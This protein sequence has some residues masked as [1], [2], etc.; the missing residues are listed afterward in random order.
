MSANIKV[1]VLVLGAGPAGINAAVAAARHGLTVVLVDQN[2]AA[3]GQVFRPIPAQFQLNATHQPSPE[4]KLGDEQRQKLKQSNVQVYASHTVWN[5]SP[6]FRVD[7]VGPDGPVH[8]DCQAV[9]AAGG[10]TERVVPFPGWTLPGVIGLAAATIMLKSQNMVP[11]NNTLVA[12]CGPLLAA[13]AAGIIK[14]GG[15]VAG[16]IDASSKSAWLKSTPKLLSRPDLMMQGVKWLTLVRKTGAPLLSSYAIEKV[17]QDGALLRATIAPVDAQRRFIHDAPRKTL[18]ADT[19][20]VGNGLVPGTDVTRAL[21]ATHTFINELGGW[22]PLIDDYC[23]TSVASLYAAGDGCGIS[24]AAAAIHH[25]ELAGL[26]VAR[27]LGKLDEQAFK[28]LADQV[29]RQLSKAQTFGQ[30]MGALMALPPLQVETIAPDTI[31]CR[32]EDITRQEID[33]A[34]S[35]GAADMNQVKAWTRCGMGPCQGR[36]CGDV[37]ASLVA[38][39]LGGREQAGYFTGRAP[40]RPVSLEQLTGD[41]EYTDIALPKAAPL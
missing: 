4:L 34:V 1:D 5:V 19:I 22:V 28:P 20:V 9:I 38:L 15:T 24:G 37:A 17:E 21:R 16:V 26:T 25:G 3:G 14:G 12:G 31:V 40:M 8:W 11:G 6:G 33:D 35:Q 29:R 2:H 7:A 13:V 32:C 27:D 30:A 39:K 23:R 10:T 36:T 18:M 41:Y